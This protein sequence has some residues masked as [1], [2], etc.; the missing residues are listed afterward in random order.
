MPWLHSCANSWPTCGSNVTT[1]RPRRRTGSARRRTYCRRRNRLRNKRQPLKP[2]PQPSLQQQATG[3]AAPGTG[4]ARRGDPT[5]EPGL[6]D[7]E[8]ID[9]AAW[10]EEV[11][12][13]K[14][15]QWAVAT[16][17]VVLCGGF[18]AAI[19]NLHFKMTEKIVAMVI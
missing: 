6:S 8:K 4:C 7:R 10:H 12:F 2:R 13:Y 19:N 5:M 3:Y 9:R 17:G 11:R 16:A 18:V 15:Q 14:K 1:G